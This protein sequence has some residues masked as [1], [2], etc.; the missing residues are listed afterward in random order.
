MK[1]STLSRP[2]GHRRSTPKAPK[3]LPRPEA[4]LWRSIVDR[5][6][7]GDGASLAL[8]TVTLEAH[9][10][11]R[12]C[13]EA[14]DRDGEAVADRF[15]QLRAHP[16]LAAERDARAAFL[17]GMRVLDLDLGTET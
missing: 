17:A 8:L 14:V 6:A 16:L 9:A 15:K 1:P 7:F 4:A 5:F 3:H 2:A 13:R 12:R 10:R 11:A